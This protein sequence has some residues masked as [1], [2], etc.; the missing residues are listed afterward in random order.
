MAQETNGLYNL[1]IYLDV[2]TTDTHI[3]VSVIT[4]I[5]SLAIPQISMGII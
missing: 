3:I 1:G 5:R 2:I 4:L